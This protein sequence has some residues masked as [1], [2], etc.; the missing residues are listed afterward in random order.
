[1]SELTEGRMQIKLEAAWEQLNSVSG[2]L[3]DLMQAQTDEDRVKQEKNVRYHLKAA[4]DY[5]TE[6]ERAM[7]EKWGSTDGQLCPYDDCAHDL[8]ILRSGWWLCPNC[9]RP[10]HAVMAD[11]IEDYHCYKPGE[12]RA[13][14]VPNEPM[15][16]ARDLGP[17]YAT[18]KPDKSKAE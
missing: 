5:V 15:A 2:A 8:A 13:G 14:Q 16:M 7:L 10:F 18:P 1:M 4:L 3:H 6:V 9:K 11:G 17:S 12:K